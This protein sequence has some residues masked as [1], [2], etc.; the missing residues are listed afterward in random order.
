MTIS[1]R[2]ASSVLPSPF[3]L[4]AFAGFS[5]L[6]IFLPDL[7]PSDLRWLFKIIPIMLL[8]QLALSRTSG[9]VRTLLVAGLVLSATGDVLL[10]MDGLF[11]HGLLAFLLAQITYTVLFVRQSRWQPRR[12]PWG[13]LIVLYTIV[14]SVFI[15]PHAGDMTVPGVAYLIAIS[16]MAISAGFRDSSQ[17]LWVAIG[18]LAFMI[19]D[20]LIAVGRFVT[21]FEYSGV[22]VM[23]SYYAAQ[24]LIVTG[25]VNDA[26]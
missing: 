3:W 21:P 19:S 25:V 4:A 26:D 18:A 5:V 10:T 23:L 9:Q 17:F 7:T 2:A 8:L 13:M 16:L 24:F 22:A 20:T 6:Y 15:L 12:L 14:I 11:V 1:A